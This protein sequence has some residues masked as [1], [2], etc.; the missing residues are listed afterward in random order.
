MARLT[1][2]LLITVV[3]TLSYI[4]TSNYIKN[5]PKVSTYSIHEEPS[6]LDRLIKFVMKTKEDKRHSAIIKIS[7]DVKKGEAGSNCTAFVINNTTAI[8]AAHCLKLTFEFIKYEFPR[9]TKQSEEKEQ[10]L[11]SLITY[12]ETN[13]GENPQCLQRLAEVEVM[14]TK[15]LESREKALAM[16]PETF[17]VINVDG[18]DTKIKAIAYS[19]HTKRDYGFLQGDFKNFKKLYI[20]SGWHVRVGDTL[21]ACGFFGG[22]L[23]PTCVDFKALGNQ[24]FQY[25]GEAILLPGVSGGP[26][27]DEDGYVA[28]VAVSVG[29][30]FVLMEPTIGMVDILTDE[31]QKR[32]NEQK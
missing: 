1:R 11:L 17:S 27:I 22:K 15:E 9:I 26:V 10:K 21:M 19:K 7:Q 32:I 30:R 13:C 24:S 29:N 14:L 8:T 31:Q 20:R 12:L 4:T 16:K 6:P 28:G 23:P 5:Q 2:I 3:L 25:A 18:V